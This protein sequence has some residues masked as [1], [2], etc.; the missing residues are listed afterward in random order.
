MA[1]NKR[2]CQFSKRKV[3]G[4]CAVRRRIH[5][6]DESRRSQT[7][8]PTRRHWLEDRSRRN[9]ADPRF[10]RFCEGKTVLRLVRP[11]A[12]APTAY[13]SRKI[14]RQVSTERQTTADCKVPGDVR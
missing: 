9:A 4:R 12:A 11:D 14:A 1:A 13:A 8:W 10:H 2:V 5:G 3:V 6:R 7:R